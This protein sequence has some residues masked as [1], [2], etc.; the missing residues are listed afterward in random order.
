MPIRLI[1]NPAKEDNHNYPLN[2]A[3]FNVHFTLGGCNL[4]VFICNGAGYFCRTGF[5]GEIISVG[6]NDNAFRVGGFILDLVAYIIGIGD[7]RL[8]L[9][10]L[11]IVCLNIIELHGYRFEL[12]D[13]FGFKSV[14]I[15]TIT[16]FHSVGNCCRSG[17]NL[18]FA[19]YMRRFINISCL[20]HVAAR[21]VS[22]FNADFC[23]GCRR[24]KL[25]FSKIMTER[26]GI[27][28]NITVIAFCAGVSR[29]SLLRACWFGHNSFVIVNITS[30]R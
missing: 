23:A 17:R 27:V 9:S 14:A 18:P 24:C 5:N 4:A 16:C 6:V 10:G 22:C 28:I 30:C 3:I 29:I 12:A 25:P 7:F 13:T 21:A 2:S 8:K 11:F 26:I 19:E 20:R 1:P 15:F